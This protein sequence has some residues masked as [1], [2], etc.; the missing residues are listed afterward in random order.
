MVQGQARHDLDLAVIEA[1]QFRVA[2]E[3]IR[4]LLV[5]GVR[6]EEAGI[7]QQ[8]GVFQQF[9]GAAIIVQAQRLPLVEQGQ[10]QVDDVGGMG[11]VHAGRRA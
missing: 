8:G 1:Q 2:D 9:A 5:V 7:V 10:G 4:V 6:D 3:I 11:L